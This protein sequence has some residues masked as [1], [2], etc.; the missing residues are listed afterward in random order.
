MECVL[1][2]FINPDRPVEEERVA[3]LQAV[4]AHALDALGDLTRDLARI[5][6]DD[7]VMTGDVIAQSETQEAINLL[8]IGRRFAGAGEDQRIRDPGIGRVQQD[9]EQIENLLGSTDAAWCGVEPR[10][11][12]SLA[13]PDSQPWAG[14]CCRTPSACG[15]W[16]P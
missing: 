2:A 1:Q 11:N 8:E 9:A 15:V 12:F 14:K 7:L 16:Q 10:R 13:A 4:L 6:D 3:V 5:V